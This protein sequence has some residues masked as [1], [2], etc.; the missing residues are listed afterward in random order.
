MIWRVYRTLTISWRPCNLAPTRAGIMSYLDEMLYCQPREALPSC[1][2][3]CTSV[4][5]VGVW[6]NAAGAKRC[7]KPAEIR[8]LCTEATSPAQNA[9]PCFQPMAAC[10]FGSAYAAEHGLVIQ[11]SSTAA[12]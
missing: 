12:D 7:A 3:P 5:Q 4:K 2:G 9:G 6:V 1:A 8:K 10:D 11:G